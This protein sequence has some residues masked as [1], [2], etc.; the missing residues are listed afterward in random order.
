MLA[1]VFLRSYSKSKIPRK[2]LHRPIPQDCAVQST[3]LRPLQASLDFESLG[4]LPNLTI[5]MGGNAFATHDPPLPTPRLGLSE[6]RA[7]RDTLLKR[8][9]EYVPLRCHLLLFKTWIAQSDANA[10]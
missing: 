5:T 1:I 7:M 10:L 3:Y 8:L 6:Y 4:I 9:S 2:A